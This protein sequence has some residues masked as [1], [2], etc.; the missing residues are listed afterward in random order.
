MAR[1]VQ[2][3]H[4]GKIQAASMWIRQASASKSQREPAP[5]R[6][7]LCLDRRAAVLRS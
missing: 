2:K 1:M 7:D 4:P 6:M 5:N 3:P